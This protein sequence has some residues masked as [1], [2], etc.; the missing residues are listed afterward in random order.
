[1][2]VRISLAILFLTL[3]GCGSDGG[4]GDTCTPQEGQCPNVC[5]GGEA[6]EGEACAT[7][8]DCACPNACYGGLCAPYEGDN[9]GCACVEV[10]QP[11][12]GDTAGDVTEDTGPNINDC[13]KAAPTGATCNPYCNLGCDDGEM[14]TYDFGAFQCLPIGVYGIGE[15]CGSSTACEE[16]MAC[17]ALT[18]EPGETCHAFCIDD[19]DCPDNR[20]CDQTVNFSSGGGEAAQA[21]FCSD[22]VTGCDAFSETNDCGDTM[23]CY[24]DKKV[25]KCM[26][27]GALPLGE[28]CD[29]PNDCAP[30]LHC[31][32]VCT[33]ICG[34]TDAPLCTNCGGT[35]YKVTTTDEPPGANCAYGGTKVDVGLGADVEGTHYACDGEPGPSDPDRLV[36]V[37]TEGEGANCAL[38]GKKISLGIDANQD[39]VLD[40]GE[41]DETSYACNEPPT[42]GGTPAMA[43]VIS[44]PDGAN[45]ADGG[46]KVQTGLDDNGNGI[47][48]DNEVT[49]TTYACDTADGDPGYQSLATVVSEGAGGN[50][51]GGGKKI[52]TGAD[53]N[54]NGIL[55]DEEVEQTSY[56]CNGT[57]DALATVKDED[58]GANC[59]DGGKKVAWGEDSNFNGTLDDDEV[60]GSTY[61]CHK[62]AEEPGQSALATVGTEDAGENCAYGGKK[63]QTG[64]DASDDGVLDD[65]EVSDTTYACDATPEGIGAS[66]LVV[67]TNVAPGDDCTEGGKQIQAGTDSNSNGQLDE[68]EIDDTQLACAGAAGE[69]GA[70]GLVD[71][72]IEPPGDTCL[73]GGKI[74]ALGTDSNEDGSL[75]DD[76]IVVSG[77]GCNAPPGSGGGESQVISQ[78]N[79]VGICLTEDAPS[80]CN[81]FTQEGCGQ[82]QKCAMVTGGISCVNNGS[83]DVGESCADAG[84]KA[85]GLCVSATCAEICSQKDDADASV[86]CDEVCASSNNITPAIWGVGICTD[87]APAETCDFWKQD[88]EDPTKYCYYVTGGATCLSPSADGQEGDPCQFIQECGQ[89]LMCAGNLCVKPC[90]LDEV[91]APP[92]ADLCVDCPGDFSPISFEN[93]IGV[94]DG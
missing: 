64:L 16:G 27:A 92:E 63:V 73:N 18:G 12:G 20:K 39:G 26:E 84:C 83:Q 1:M 89:G 91:S 85:G 4:G 17:F 19:S 78:D 72:T 29:A 76:E 70:Q 71:V 13:P 34:V 50:C 25:T 37:T 42:S 80:T 94:C 62:A 87:N 24:L 30:G 74:Y 60:T 57:A 66:A 54:T 49:D 35:P 41:V 32:V 15:P 81:I 58:P 2:K 11:D 68:D 3:V 55:D 93:Q 79:G 82:G 75:D 51:A 28:F 65:D 7:S 59:E 36:T 53:M 52:Q 86:D 45:C 21:K 40:D 90:S 8:A 22:V 6:L 43:M 5:A 69:S 56:A 33:E 14:C 31:L 9:A 46:K 48:D 61:A 23:A 67:V 38:G 88:C 77:T 10:P 44:E 47:L